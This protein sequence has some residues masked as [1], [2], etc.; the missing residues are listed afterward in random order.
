MRVELNRIPSIHADDEAGIPGRTV[1]D[2]FSTDEERATLAQVAE[3]LVEEPDAF[4]L[5]GEQLGVLAWAVEVIQLVVRRE[6]QQAS[7]DQRRMWS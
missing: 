1:W 2:V 7:S 6:E 5:D 3:R 4:Q